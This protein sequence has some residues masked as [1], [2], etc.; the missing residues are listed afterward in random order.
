MENTRKTMIV[1]NPASGGGKGADRWRKIKPIMDKRH[2]KYDCIVTGRRDDATEL[3]RKALH[4]GYDQIIAVGGDG[5]VHETVNGFFDDYEV[6]NGD[7]VIGIVP[8]GTGSDFARTLGVPRNS[9]ESLVDVL[10]NGRI[11]PLDVGYIETDDYRGYFNNITGV[12][13]EGKMVKMVNE[14]SKR[15]GGTVPYMYNI[16]RCMLTYKNPFLHVELD[17]RTFDEVMC[18]VSVA[19][20]KYF[21][22]GMCI[23]PEASINDGLFDIIMVD[24]M[25][26]FQLIRSF[27][28]IY[29]G[30]IANKK[31]ISLYRS[32]HVYISCEGGEWIDSDGETIGTIPV[33]FDVLPSIINVRTGE[34]DTDKQNTEPG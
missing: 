7:A 26:M 23:A 19:N 4:E 12:G 29:S 9:N 5:T 3:T 27:R 34:I 33:S 8:V 13:F 1:V 6:I 16:L 22:G 18:F 15:F 28:K 2:F 24:D 31:G 10:I 30:D 32:K 11:V 21:G 14:G 20:G 17:D 25:S